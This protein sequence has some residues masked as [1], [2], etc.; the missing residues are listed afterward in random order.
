LTKYED[1]LKAATDTDC[2]FHI[3]ALVGPYHADEAYE[4]V[5]YLGTV[6]VLNAC[7]ALGI[8]KIV[9]SSSPSTRFPHPDPS[10]SGLTEH[11]LFLKNGG[12]YAP[13][14]LQPY[15]RTKAMGEKVILDACGNKEGD[16]LTIAVAP[17]QVVIS[18]NTY[19]N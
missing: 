18:C 9:M 3:A 12:D 4:K 7:K 16:L 15:A 5:N 8:K 1:V 17:H 6:H 19:Q 11:Q 2:I 10:I 13:V 14:F